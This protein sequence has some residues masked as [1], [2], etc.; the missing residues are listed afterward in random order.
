MII[1]EALKV[2]A[3][4]IGGRDKCR[5]VKCIGTR[6]VEKIPLAFCIEK[7]LFQFEMVQWE[8]QQTYSSSSMDDTVD[9]GE[10]VSQLGIVYGW[11]SFWICFEINE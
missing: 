4:C 1:L 3:F 11:V 2:C 6:F 9:F 7:L 8:S 5:T 10:T